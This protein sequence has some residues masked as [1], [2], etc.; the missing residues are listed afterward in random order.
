V[1]FSNLFLLYLYILIFDLI[2][3]LIFY[4]NLINLVIIK[5]GKF[6][7]FGFRFNKTH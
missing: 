5:K 4:F 7:S 6:F 2:F 1:K 3:D